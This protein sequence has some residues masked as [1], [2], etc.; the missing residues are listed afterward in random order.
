MFPEKFFS[1]AYK[2]VLATEE[3]IFFNENILKNESHFFSDQAYILINSN[4]IY[5]FEKSKSN[6]YRMSFTIEMYASNVLFNITGEDS[7]ASLTEERK[8]VPEEDKYT[9]SQTEILIEDNGWLGYL[10]GLSENE[11]CSRNLFR[12]YPTDLA[13]MSDNG[14]KN[15]EIFLSYEYA[16]DDT[17]EFNNI[18]LSDGIAIYSSSTVSIDGRSMIKVVSPISHNLSNNDLITIYTGVDS[19]DYYIYSIGDENRENNEHMFILDEAASLSDLSGSS[20]KRKINGIVSKYSITK[21]KKLGNNILLYKNAFANT[22]YS[23]LV[24]SLNVTEEL[25]VAD[26]KDAFGYPLTKLFLTIV[27]KRHT[28]YENFFFNS[29]KSGVYTLFANSDYDIT[30]LTDVLGV[31][32]ED[33]IN[34]ADMYG[35]IVEYN[36]MEQRIY[37][38]EPVYHRFNSKNRSDNGYHEGYYYAPHNVIQLKEFS[39]YL[40]DS[41]DLQTPDYA[42]QFDEN[43]F[44]YR[45]LA[46]NQFSYKWPFLNGVFY[47]YKKYPFFLRRQDPCFLYGN[48][49]QNP[50]KG[51]CDDFST[52]KVNL[53]EILC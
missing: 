2:H 53:P 11:G 33:D 16:K 25:N 26:M 46:G 48:G 34:I 43:R 42:Y 15:Y 31:S 37:Y 21:H 22:V 20:F 9:F 12:P 17:V 19:A 7:Y 18:P 8:Y 29:V 38:L 35:N 49:Y 50:I 5:N 40:N 47:S 52:K 23:D 24:F 10:T 1:S 51:Y 44:I 14:F 3:P 27:K 4:A 30:T 45:D 39:E 36:E 41:N 6:N 32:L 13:L 28:E